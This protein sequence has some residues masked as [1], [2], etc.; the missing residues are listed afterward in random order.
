MASQDYKEKGK[1]YGGFMS[2][3]KWV[4]PVI[5]VIVFAVVALIS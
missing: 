1:L 5:G 3:V 4:I 2:T